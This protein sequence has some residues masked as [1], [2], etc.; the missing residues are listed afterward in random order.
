[1]RWCNTLRSGINRRHYTD[2]F[3]EC[4]FLNENIRIPIHI[5]LKFVSKGPINTV[6]LL[7]QK[8]AWRR[9]GDKPLSDRWWLDYWCKYA[10]LG[11]LS[12]WGT[13]VSTGTHISVIFWSLRLLQNQKCAYVYLRQSTVN[14]LIELIQNIISLNDDAIF[15]AKVLLNLCN[16]RMFGMLVP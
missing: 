8:M 4:I 1:M 9:P 10:S 5:I 3:F 12:L 15:V 16:S 7:V 11:S 2:N 14:L 13:R 6:P